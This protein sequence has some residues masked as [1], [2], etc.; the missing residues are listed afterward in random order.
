MNKYFLVNI[1]IVI[2]VK[3]MTFQSHNSVFPGLIRRM[4]VSVSVQ[5][6][7]RRITRTSRRNHQKI[8]FL[9]LIT[10][11]ETYLQDYLVGL[12]PTL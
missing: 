10:S 1:Y 3:Y 9:Q 2:Y 4:E 12:K 7:E 6:I 11:E 8:R 5:L